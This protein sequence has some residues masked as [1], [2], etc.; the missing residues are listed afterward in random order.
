MFSNLRT[1]YDSH[2]HFC[3]CV[4]FWSGPVSHFGKNALVGI[5]GDLKPILPRIYQKDNGTFSQKNVH[6]EWKE[7]GWETQD[8]Q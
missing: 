5:Q 3:C 7:Q 8:Y 2:K 1:F 6:W 4:L